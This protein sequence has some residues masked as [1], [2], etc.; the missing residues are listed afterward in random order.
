MS[1]LS[2]RLLIFSLFLLHCL[3]TSLLLGLLY[4]WWCDW[5]SYVPGHK[6]I[7]LILLQAGTALKPVAAADRMWTCEVGTSSESFLLLSI[8]S[9]FLPVIC[10]E[11]KTVKKIGNQLYRGIY[12]FT[13][14]LAMQ[15]LK[16]REERNS[17]L[18]NLCF[19]LATFVLFLFVKRMGRPFTGA[20]GTTRCFPILLVLRWWIAELHMRSPS[21]SNAS[22][23][24]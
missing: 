18:C 12:W 17:C 21:L 4:L 7:Q 24:Y 15:H 16:R 1:S 5:S 8:F 20:G 10:I 9:R 11:Q 19:V 22:L 3:N 13:L 23:H 6:V 2:P 14:V